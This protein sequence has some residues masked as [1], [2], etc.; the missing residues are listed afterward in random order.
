MQVQRGH[1]TQFWYSIEKGVMSMTLHELLPAFILHLDRLGRSKNTQKSYHFDL[2]TF[3][4][5]LEDKSIE[6]AASEYLSRLLSEGRSAS[7]CNRFLSSLN[8]FLRF[9]ESRGAEGIELQIRSMPKNRKSRIPIPPNAIL[10]PSMTKSIEEKA[11]DRK[12]WLVAR[13][14]LVVSL[15]KSFGLTP[16]ELSSIT[17]S[18]IEEQTIHLEAGRSI[19]LR[20]MTLEL[21]QHYS[22]LID[23]PKCGYLFYRQGSSGHYPVSTRTIERVLKASAQYGSPSGYK[24]YQVLRSEVNEVRAK[25]LG[26]T[27]ASTMK[28]QQREVIQTMIKNSR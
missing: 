10:I 19:H 21:F 2:H 22:T 3:L 27:R 24:N 1:S 14:A 16:K 5:S 23:A 9:A 18:A 17:I 12:K 4:G 8:S 25:Q 13:N 20:D 26:Y 6:Q 11:S 15:A 7:T 28:E